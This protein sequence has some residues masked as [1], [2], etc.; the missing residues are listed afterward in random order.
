V[1]DI[2]IDIKSEKCN[3]VKLYNPANG[4][5]HEEELPLKKKIGQY[6]SLFLIEK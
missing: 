5:I 4:N 2:H 6:E 1:K 3:M